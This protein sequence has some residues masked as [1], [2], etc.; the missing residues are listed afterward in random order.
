[1]T[2]ARCPGHQPGVCVEAASRLSLGVQWTKERGRGT[3][4]VQGLAC[5]LGKWLRRERPC[6]WGQL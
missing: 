5:G 3:G 6:V 1:M 4:H 2:R